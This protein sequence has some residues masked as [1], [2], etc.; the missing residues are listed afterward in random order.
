MSADS[1][2]CAHC[3]PEQTRSWSLLTASSVLKAQQDA[4]KP[5]R[6]ANQRSAFIA[7]V[8]TVDLRRTSGDFVL[9]RAKV[10]AA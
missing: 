10:A 2:D 6:P 9:F 4:R 8:H 7:R 1:S 5:R 3:A